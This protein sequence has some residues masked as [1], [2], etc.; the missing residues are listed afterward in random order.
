[1]AVAARP[2]TDRVDIRQGEEVSRFLF[3]V[4]IVSVFAASVVALGAPAQAPASAR[5][6][7]RAALVTKIKVTAKDFKFVLS[8]KTAKR[9]IVVFKVTNLGAVKH[10]F[11][12]KGRTTRKLSHGQS[13]TLRVTFLRKGSYPYKCTVDHHADL[14]MKGV[15]TIT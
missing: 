5:T 12:I 1:V 11:H 14:G 10:D 2:R 15:F 6:T 9:G 4:T 3:R 8:K 13:A 7:Q